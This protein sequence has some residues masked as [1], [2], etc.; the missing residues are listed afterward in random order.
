VWDGE[1]GDTQKG[2]AA[3]DLLA[4]VLLGLVG[5]FCY[6]VWVGGRA[7]Y[8][9]VAGEQLSL[10]ECTSAAGRQLFF[11]LTTSGVSKHW[12]SKTMTAYPSKQK[13]RVDD[14][15]TCVEREVT[16]AEALRFQASN[17]G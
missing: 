6:G 12:G 4:W 14:T 9:S 8:E 5:L 1:M 16:E 2:S 7:A 10:V 15:A 11:G 13:I 3:A 17:G